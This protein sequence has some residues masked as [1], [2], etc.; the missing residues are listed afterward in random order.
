[1]RPPTAGTFTVRARWVNSQPFAASPSAIHGRAAAYRRLSTTPLVSRPLSAQQKTFAAQNPPSPQF[2]FLRSAFL[3]KDVLYRTSSIYTRQLHSQSP[4]FQ[5]AQKRTEDSV[6]DK[7]S[8]PEWTAK[9]PSSSESAAGQKPAG[10]AGEAGT[11]GE[12]QGNKAGEEGAGGQKEGAEEGEQGKKKDAP[13][14]PPHGD[15]TPWQVFTETLKSEFQASKEWNE[16]TKQLSA[17]VNDFTQNPHV[18]KARTTYNQVTDAATTKTAEALKT[19]GRV[20]GHGAAWTWD[21]TPMKGVRKVAS[22]TGSGIEHVTRPVR[23]SKAFQA[24]KET[25]DDGSSSRYGGWVEKEERR[26]RR[27]LRELNEL[28]RSGGKHHTGPMEED[29]DAGT[30]VTLHKDAK[31]KEIWREFKDSS[32]LMQG[33]FN[34]QSVYKESENPLITTARSISDRVTGFFAENE[35][36]MVIKKFREMDPSFQLEPFLTE[37]REYI[38]PEVLDAYVKGDVETLKLWLSAAQYSVYAALMQQYT[39]AGLKSDGRIVDIR[40]VDILSARLLEP[41]E[42]PVFIITCRTQE[43]HVYRNAKTG[44]LAAGM[45]DKVQ[46][47]TYAIGVTR[48]PEDVNNPETRGWRLIELQKSARDYY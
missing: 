34:M 36:A 21:T 15:K 41:G 10:Q 19:T 44:D 14:P 45:D 8:E 25:V 24:V 33:L 2:L 7:E 27:E 5:Q 39:T 37:M 28:Q 9:Q 31:Y 22:V 6:R 46:Q 29:P 32:R 4:L 11:E 1:M 12:S 35:T 3:P 40:H 48:I 47:V 43:V 42:V 13:P 30:N 26:R 16:S 17:G 18:Q 38:L 20:I 23:Q